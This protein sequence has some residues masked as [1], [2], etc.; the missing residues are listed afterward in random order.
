MVADS[1]VAVTI[2]SLVLIIVLL[3]VFAYLML[4]ERKFLGWFHLRLGPNRTGPWGL[5]QPIADGVKMIFKEDII[6]R[7]ADRFI[8]KLAPVIS[9][10]VAFAAFAVIPVG[11]PLKIGNW[12]VPLSIADP[13]AGVLVLLAFTSLGVY[14]IALGGWASQSKYS[15]LGALRSTAQMISYELTM[16]MSLVGVILLAGSLR[17]SD[18]VTAQ[19]SLWFI[20]RQPV[21]F[22]L[23][24]ISVVA[25]VN[26][27][28]FDLPEA[29][30]ELVAGYHTEY[31]G[32][33][34]AMFAIAEYVNMITVSSLVTLLYL[35]GWRGPAF[36]PPVVW[37]LLKVS[38]FV[39]LFIWMRATLPRLRYDR[40]MA[41]GW[42][43]MLPV[44]FL[45][46]VATAAWVAF[47]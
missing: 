19:E 10:F 3:T 41:F 27:V 43:V 16:G 30:T 34:F 5:A 47:R 42:K 4:F 39:F 38:F 37:F 9:L 13:N 7:D 1:L 28:P 24:F 11:P 26:R 15:L 6:P 40:L 36:L 14:G 29:E 45:N 23:F 21:G 8:F 12:T 25:E 2:R 32:M 18:I 31:S 33:R 20:V 35:G 46:L 22:I 44:A 17:L